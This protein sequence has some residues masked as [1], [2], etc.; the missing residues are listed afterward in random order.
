MLMLQSTTG[1]TYATCQS[2][3]I[4]VLEVS[5]LLLFEISESL[6]HNYFIVLVLASSL[7]RYLSTM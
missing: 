4:L 7:I 1:R 2:C 3:K 5:R 6:D